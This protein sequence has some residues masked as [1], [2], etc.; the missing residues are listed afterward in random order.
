LMVLPARPAV[1]RQA[2]RALLSSW[3]ILVKAFQ[4]G[5]GGGALKDGD[6]R[7]VALHR[8]VVLH[9]RSMQAAFARMSAVERA[10]NHATVLVAGVAAVCFA[11]AAQIRPLCSGF[12]HR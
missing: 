9:L 4:L 2:A 3:S 7:S 5:L 8:V 6:R 10:R 1:E 11:H 12:A